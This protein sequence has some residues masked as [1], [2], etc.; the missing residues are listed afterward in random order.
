[1]W[2]ERY[3]QPGFHFGQEPADFLVREA[4]RLAPGSRVLCVAD[5]EGRN[6]TWLAGRGC[7]VVAMDGSAVAI[8]KARDLAARR[9]VAV[10]FH[11]ADVGRWPWH[12]AEYD[13]VVAIFVQFADPVLRQ[14]MF[15]GMVQTLRPGG[16]LLLHGYTP[17]QL[18][19]GTG[20]P[21]QVDHLYTADMLA[22]A[23]RG[24]DLVHLAEYEAVLSEGSGHVGPSS[25][26][27]LIARKP[28]GRP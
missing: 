4:Y 10:A 11:H 1:M 13:A 22:D 8:A 6:S 17:R 19:H 12:E 9:G 28:E 25:L 24:L 23:F 18:V 16:L 14:A 20:G 3:A 27:D 2:D 7:D 15:A 26:I 5:G 21:R